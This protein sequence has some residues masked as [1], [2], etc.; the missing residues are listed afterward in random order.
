MSKG[1]RIRCAIPEI[2]E[3]IAKLDESLKQMIGGNSF[4]FDDEEPV[5]RSAL[6]REHGNFKS[7][8]LT[9]PRDTYQRNLS[10]KEQLK[11]FKEEYENLIGTI[12]RY[13]SGQG[14]TQ[15]TSYDFLTDNGRDSPDSNGRSRSKKLNTDTSSDNSTDSHK[16]SALLQ[17]ETDSDKEEPENFL[18][19]LSRLRAELKQMEKLLSDKSSDYDHEQLMRAQL[20]YENDQLMQNKAELEGKLTQLQAEK[21]KLEVEYNVDRDIYET[22]LRVKDEQHDKDFELSYAQQKQIKDLERNIA[23]LNKQ[24]AKLQHAGQHASK[25]DQQKFLEREQELKILYQELSRVKQDLAARQ[26]EA[27]V[28]QESSAKKIAALAQQLKQSKAEQQEWLSAYQ[29][30]QESNQKLAAQNNL[31]NDDLK[32]QQLQEEKLQAR[33]AKLK[34]QQAELV[35][36]LTDYSTHQEKTTKTEPKKKEEA[37]LIKQPPLYQQSSVPRQSFALPAPSYYSYPTYSNFVAPAAPAYLNVSAPAI[38]KPAEI[39]QTNQPE[40]SQENWQQKVSQAKARPYQELQ[41]NQQAASQVNNSNNQNNFN[42]SYY[43]SGSTTAI[44]APTTIVVAATVNIIALTATLSAL[45]AV[46]GAYFAY[47]Y[48]NSK[49]S[50]FQPN[51]SAFAR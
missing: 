31:F 30:L 16:I 24:I 28:T 19:E 18:D 29:K 37:Q 25:K 15:N 13:I 7:V 6:I 45:T 46:S 8:S 34:E 41:Y 21:T 48:L 49:S 26:S 33:E 27:D 12:N 40:T 39:T 42:G 43:V 2:S 47:N 50:N 9:I 5:A 14:L 36:M 20:R 11:S 3:K 44:L 35:K 22:R 4:S 51:N 38:T 32:T 23:D 1:K 10:I 17:P